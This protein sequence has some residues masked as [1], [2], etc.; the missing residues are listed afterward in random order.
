MVDLEKGIKTSA[1]YIL[2]YSW[3]GDITLR[4][5]SEGVLL[6]LPGES[7][8]PPCSSVSVTRAARTN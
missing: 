8:L 2:T 4:Y 6:T 5:E 1:E 3:R 7:R